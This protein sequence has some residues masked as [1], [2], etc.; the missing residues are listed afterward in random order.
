[1]IR[2]LDR[3]VAREFTKLFVL[4][5]LGLPMLFIIGDWTDHIDE[6]TAP[7]RGL[8]PLKVALGYFY[9]MPQFVSYSFPIAA[10]VATVFT[11]SNL[12]RHSEMS[13]AKAGGIS[14]YRVLAVLPMIGILL[15][16]AGLGLS[17]LIPK[18]TQKKNEIMGAKDRLNGYSRSDFVYGSPEGDAVIVR[19]LDVDAKRINGIAIQREGNGVTTP[20]ELII[21]DSARYDKGQ[22]H[23]FNGIYR[24]F[25]KDTI[26]NSFQFE[27]MVSEHFRE[28]PATL[29]ATPKE[30][31][32]MTYAE[33]G[34]YIDVQQRSGT[35]PKKLMVERMAKISIPVATLII[36]MFGAPLANTS[37]RGGPAYGIGLSLGI[38]V[39][40]LMLFNVTNALGRTGVL[41]PFW[42]A[43]LPNALFLVAAVIATMRVRT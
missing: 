18:G 16:V 15:T 43:W 31:E 35:Q 25:T 7:G 11:V 14:F 29:T 20:T 4:A 6:Y 37:A 28:E 34:H 2:I 38:T 30:P 39:F 27:E 36:I 8:T 5:A 12:T 17:E 41:T 24:V 26:E 22:W 13:A 19:T 10:L 23:L 33:L 32:E 3:Y 1:M 9:Q 42:G 21:A 40:Y